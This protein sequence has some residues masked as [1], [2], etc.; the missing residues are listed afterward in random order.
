M[1]GWSKLDILDRIY[2]I[3]NSFFREVLNYYFCAILYFKIEKKSIIFKLEINSF[4]IRRSS[5]IDY[6]PKTNAWALS[7]D[8]SKIPLDIPEQ[9]KFIIPLPQNSIKPTRSRTHIWRA[10]TTFHFHSIFSRIETKRRHTTLL[11]RNTNTNNQL[12]KYD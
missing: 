5:F 2:Q 9:T 4:T 10:S 7:F 1:K 3:D 12:S 11:I 8:F 6:T